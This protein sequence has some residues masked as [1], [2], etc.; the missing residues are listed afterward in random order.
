MVHLNGGVTQPGAF[1]GVIATL[2]EG[3]RPSETVYMATNLVAA[4]GPARI[5]V[6]PTGDINIQVAAAA[7]N[8]NAQDFTSLT[9]SFVP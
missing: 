6:T 3:F 5:Y 2:P 7:T 8:A 1:N 9:K 4:V